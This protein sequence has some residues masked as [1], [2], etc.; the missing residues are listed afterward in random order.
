M[1]DDFDPKLKGV[2]IQKVVERDRKR[3]ERKE[4]RKEKKKKEKKEHI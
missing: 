3:R 4:E 1:K 2:A